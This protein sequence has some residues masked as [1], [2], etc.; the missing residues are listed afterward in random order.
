MRVILTKGNF[1][2][3]MKKSKG[4]LKVS[5]LLMLLKRRL[6]K[7]LSFTHLSSDG[8]EN[9]SPEASAKKRRRGVRA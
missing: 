7:L 3:G 1:S 2:I 6:N 9:D 5:N 8:V 4:C